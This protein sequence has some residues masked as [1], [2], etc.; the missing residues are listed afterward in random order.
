MKLVLCIRC[1]DVFK[2][3]YEL[4]RCRCGKSEGA[5]I[6]DKRAWY[7]GRNAVPIGLDNNGIRRAVVHGD[8]RLEMD[9]NGQIV[10]SPTLRFDAW[11]FA[12]GYWAFEHHPDEAPAAKGRKKK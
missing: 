4:R 9:E 10:V 8:R 2:L 3:E 7:R 11:V 1:S 12:D 5:Y 6:D